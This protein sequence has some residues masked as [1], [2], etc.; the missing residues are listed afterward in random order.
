MATVK[1]KLYIILSLCLECFRVFQQEQVFTFDKK[2]RNLMIYGRNKSGKT[3]FID[4]L[5]FGLSQDGRVNRLSF[6]PNVEKI[7]GGQV[8]LFNYRADLKGEKGA[9]QIVIDF[10]EGNKDGKFT[11][12]RKFENSEETKSD[13]HIKFLSKM[14][15]LPIIR[16]E[17]L[18]FFVSVWISTKR[19]EGIEMW[20]QHLPEFKQWNTLSLAVKTIKEEFSKIVVA[21]SEKVAKLAEITNQKVVAWSE[22]AILDYINNNVLAQ[23]ETGLIMSK[24]EKSDPAHKKLAEIMNTSKNRSQVSS[25]NATRV[26]DVKIQELLNNVNNILKLKDEYDELTQSVTM[27]TKNIKDFE[28]VEKSY[29][30]ELKRVVKRQI[31]KLHKPM[32]E[33]YQYIQGN[34]EQIIHLRLVSDEETAQEGFNLAVDVTNDRKEVMPGDY[35]TCAEKQSFALAFHLATIVKFNPEVPIIILDD[36][37]LSYDEESR[38]RITALIVE[39]F[40]EHQFIITSCDRPFCDILES[41]VDRNKWKFIEII[42]FKEDYGPIFREFTSIE[43]Q[44]KDR[45]AEGLSALWL[46]RL[47]LEQNFRQWAYQLKV[48]LPVLKDEHKTNYGLGDLIAGFQEFIKKNKVSIPRLK[49]IDTD[50]LAYLGNLFMENTGSHAQ[51]V[52]TTPFSKGDE[53]TRWHE[54]QEF[55]AMMTCKSCNKLNGF[56]NVVVRI[57]DEDSKQNLEANRATKNKRSKKMKGAF[58]CDKCKVPL[59][60]IEKDTAKVQDEQIE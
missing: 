8:A 11:I 37:L 27:L 45:W 4:A 18:L 46:M 48:K 3:A 55:M 44:I 17:E 33:Y 1:K 25:K 20:K 35:L 58:V 36:I 7:F 54:V 60:F 5:E 49:S 32:N 28:R 56:K 51:D 22:P 26:T 59:V 2:M 53:E 9:V 42:G 41:R 29:S 23:F 52:D 6:D 13:A 57:E 43:Q 40:P 14:P 24:L 50:T 12:E 16:G 10:H 31:D 21:Q 47:Y 34:S 15:V 19:F 39:K 38:N 30:N